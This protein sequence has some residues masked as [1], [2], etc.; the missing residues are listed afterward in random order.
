METLERMIKVW[1]EALE[2]DQITGD[3]DF[4]EVG[5]HSMS[6]VKLAAYVTEEFGV[7]ITIR[8]V[9][10]ATTPHDLA[11]VIDAKTLS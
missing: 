5:G 11:A 8:Q 4:Y 10:R 1:R 9:L 3:S 7:E 2:S 6:A